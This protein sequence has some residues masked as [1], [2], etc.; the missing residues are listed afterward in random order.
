M[1]ERKKLTAADLGLEPSEVKGEAVEY[2]L[3]S[4]LTAEAAI[5][6][7][8]KP[9]GGAFNDPT[10]VA[11]KKYRYARELPDLYEAENKRHQKRIAELDLEFLNLKDMAKDLAN[12]QDL[13][14][15]IRV[16]KTRRK[17]EREDLEK[18]AEKDRKQAEREV[19]KRLKAEK[20]ISTPHGALVAPPSDDESFMDMLDDLP[21][22]SPPPS[23]KA[24]PVT[25]AKAK[26]KAPISK[27]APPAKKAA[28]PKVTAPAPLFPLLAEPTEEELQAISIE[29]DTER[30]QQALSE[31]E[32]K[33]SEMGMYSNR[34]AVPPEYIIEAQQKNL[35]LIRDWHRLVLGV[36]FHPLQ[37]PRRI[38]RRW[39]AACLSLEGVILSP[40]VPL[41]DQG[42][43][44]GTVLDMHLGLLGG[45]KVLFVKGIYD[46]NATVSIDDNTTVWDVKK[47][48]QDLR[49][50]P[51]KEIRLIFAGKQLEESR[52]LREYGIGNEDTIHVVTRLRGGALF[53]ADLHCFQYAPC[54]QHDLTEPALDETGVI[55]VRHLRFNECIASC[56][57]CANDESV[58]RLMPKLPSELSSEVMKFN[59]ETH[60][61]IESV[62][63]VLAY[64]GE[65][66]KMGNP[67]LLE[68]AL[69]WLTYYCQPQEDDSNESLSQF[70]SATIG[71]QID[72]FL[73]HC[74]G[75]DEGARLFVL[76]QLPEVVE[77][78]CAELIESGA[79]RCEDKYFNHVSWESMA[80]EWNIGEDC[81]AIGFEGSSN[82][83]LFRVWDLT[84]QD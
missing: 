62:K 81:V 21:K 57:A 69:V 67:N 53:C 40:H 11:K 24:K 26:A 8:W 73:C 72:E 30:A 28:P 84:N 39:P 10:W 55:R 80:S 52:F 48:L 29:W 3:Q 25:R 46:Y 66:Y 71:D 32:E 9:R 42:V 2:D 35:I 75:D 22:E 14:E 78:R 70:Q 43:M 76:S 47:Q 82:I 54:S 37:T 74:Y 1:G 58:L 38:V 4:L 31:A 60:R 5:I 51:P 34:A 15:K 20:S 16:E 61:N 45:G 41:V 68:A 13:Q 18:Q 59:P 33:K 19:K 77:L 56:A 44:V 23:P 65:D 36:S 27:S 6:A 7:R 64:D 50:W 17:N 79:D 49:G 12:I 63:S 83:Y